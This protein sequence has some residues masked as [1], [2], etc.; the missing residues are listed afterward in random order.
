LSAG[1]LGVTHLDK[2]VITATG[3]SYLTVELQQKVQDA[4]VNG[5]EGQDVTVTTTVIGIEGELRDHLLMMKHSAVAGDAEAEENLKTLQGLVASFRPLKVVNPEA[6]RREMAE[7]AEA[8][9]KK[10]MADS[11]E[12]I[13]FAEIKTLLLQWQGIDLEDPEMRTRAMKL[14]QPFEAMAE[15]INFHDAELDEFWNALHKAQSGDATDFKA[16]LNE[17]IK[18]AASEEKEKEAEEAAQLPAAQTNAGAPAGGATDE[19]AQP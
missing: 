7:L 14:L 19:A 10:L 17:L 3:R 18:E 8:N 11:G 1:A 16:N 15:G 6:K 9:F 4:I 5:K 2:G 13:F 12:A